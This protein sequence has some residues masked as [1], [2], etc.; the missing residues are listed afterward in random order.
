MAIK[1]TSLYLNLAKI[2]IF[3]PKCTEEGRGG[4]TDFQMVRFRIG[5]SSADRQRDKFH[6]PSQGEGDD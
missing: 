4:V 2:H 5:K 1:L 6:R 3:I